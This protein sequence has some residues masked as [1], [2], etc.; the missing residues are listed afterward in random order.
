MKKFFVLTAGLLISC[1][2]FSQESSFKYEFKL[3]GVNDY[4]NAKGVIIELRDELGVKI[5]TFED[6]I[7]RFQILTHLDYPI[8]EM[9][10]DFEY[11]GYELDGEL[12][13]TIAE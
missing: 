7:D 13:K 10:G 9:I 4:G 2:S 3:V 12:I 6:T 11:M 1:W 8:A 5:I